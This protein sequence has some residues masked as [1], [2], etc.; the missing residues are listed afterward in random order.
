MYIYVYIY[1]YIYIYI[2][3]RVVPLDVRSV[4][5]AFWAARTQ[6][7]TEEERQ[8]RCSFR[9][10]RVLTRDWSDQNRVE[11]SS[12]SLTSW[13]TSFS[14]S[15]SLA[16]TLSSCPS[17]PRSNHDVR[18][19]STNQLSFLHGVLTFPPP[20]VLRTTHVFVHARSCRVNGL[21]Y[22]STVPFSQFSVPSSML[23]TF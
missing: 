7:S 4:R 13:P 19:R 23:I 1:I 8:D 5:S 9:H 22:S 18:P 20:V 16:E 3:A 15:H 11:S 6:W 21:R 10:I 2:D 14:P 12:R 17:T